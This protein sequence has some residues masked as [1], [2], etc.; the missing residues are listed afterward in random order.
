MIRRFFK[1]DL[2]DPTDPVHQKRE[3]APETEANLI[4]SMLP[5]DGWH[6]PVLDID[7]EAKLLPSTTPGHYHLYLDK[8]MRWDTYVFLLRALATAGVIEWGF[9]HLSIAR[10]AS[11]VRKPGVLKEEGDVNSATQ[12]WR[13]L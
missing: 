3:E 6:A 5:K 10:G 8:E 9:Y 12:V 1:A 4:S 7:F 11:F 13:G 2:K